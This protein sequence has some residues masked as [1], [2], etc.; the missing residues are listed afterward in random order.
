[1]PDDDSAAPL[2]APAVEPDPDRERLRGLLVAALTAAVAALAARDRLRLACYYAQ[3]LTLTQ[4]GK[5]LGE[6]EATTSRQLARTRKAL[7]AEV[8]RRLRDDHRLSP[9][10]I[11]ASFEVVAADAGAMDVRTLLASDE[12][13]KESPLERSL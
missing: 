3:E 7:R 6:H 13:R 9:P 10:E 11:A 1:L 2:P 5:L 4:T 8:E 12:P